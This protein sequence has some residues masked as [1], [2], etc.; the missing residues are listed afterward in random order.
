[1]A[2]ARASVCGLAEALAC[3]TL[4][5]SAVRFLVPY[6]LTEYCGSLSQVSVH[7]ALGRVLAR[8]GAG[9]LEGFGTLV[10]ITSISTWFAARCRHHVAGEPATIVVPFLCSNHQQKAV[11]IEPAAAWA[12][13]SQVDENSDIVYLRA[14]IGR[15]AQATAIS[16]A[17]EGLKEAWSMAQKGTMLAPWDHRSWNVLVYIRGHH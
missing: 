16:D 1:M 17:E 15:C 5:C 9:G 8:E 13:I 3:V 12:V 2:S 4:A 7:T 10:S 6:E 14:S 11:H